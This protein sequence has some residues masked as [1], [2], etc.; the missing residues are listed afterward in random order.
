MN[1]NEE[2]LSEFERAVNLDPKNPYRFSSRAFFKDRTGDLIGAI[3]DYEIAI[4]LDPEDAISLNNKGIVEEKLG[5]LAKSKKSFE[6]ADQLVGYKSPAA[7]K[8]ESVHKDQ[9]STSFSTER[10]QR[11]NLN[12]F[13]KILSDIFTDSNSRKE[14]FNFL[15]KYLK[16]NKN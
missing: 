3:A 10:S 7:Q 15:I 11:M 4:E 2:A 13:T 16:A 6:K 12:Y 5:Y 8:N 1:R 14:F 9:P